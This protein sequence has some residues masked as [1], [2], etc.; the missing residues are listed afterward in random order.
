MYSMLSTPFICCSIGVATPCSIATASAPGYVAV[1][2]SCG[3][4]ISGYCATGK[5]RIDTSPTKT[6]MIAITIATIGRL[7]KNL[8]MALLAVSGHR[9]RLGRDESAV[10]HELG[11]FDGDAL[12][13]SESRGD[14]D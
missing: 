11:A 5:A 13:A 3:G 10:L 1:P 12:A 7:M 6:V 9:E 2:S 14:D 4:T 8:D